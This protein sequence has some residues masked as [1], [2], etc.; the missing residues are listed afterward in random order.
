LK[1]A[2]AR[3]RRQGEGEKRRRGEKALGRNGMNKRRNLD[4]LKCI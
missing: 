3:K 4:K 1:G 2:R